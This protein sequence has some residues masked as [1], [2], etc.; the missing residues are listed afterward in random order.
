[1]SVLAD[2][3]DSVTLALAGS[4][5]ATTLPR[6]Q[7]IIRQVQRRQKRV[8]LDLEEVTL[9]DRFASR[10]FAG[11]REQGVKLVNCP[12]YIR[13]WISQETVYGSKK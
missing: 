8:V 13:H 4:V 3:P 10:F 12:V 9:M 5:S 2:P 6:V 11:Q 1:L 7:R